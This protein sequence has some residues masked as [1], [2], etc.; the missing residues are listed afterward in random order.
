MS[1]EIAVQKTQTPDQPKRFDVVL[2]TKLNEVATSLPQ[3][4]NIQRF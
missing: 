1:E 2:E 4:F 3:G